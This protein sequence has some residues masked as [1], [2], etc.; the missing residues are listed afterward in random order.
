MS[1]VAR[2]DGP[3]R[4]GRVLVSVIFQGLRLLELLASTTP[5]VTWPV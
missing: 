1:E 5:G 2:T 4:F 3:K